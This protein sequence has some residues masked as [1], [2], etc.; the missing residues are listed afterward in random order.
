MRAIR[1]IAIVSGMV[2]VVAVVAYLWVARAGGAVSFSDAGIERAVRSAL[3]REDASIYLTD[4]EQI[5]HLDAARYGIR[6][7]SEIDMLSNLRTLDLSGNEIESL[8][9]LRELERLEELRLADFGLESADEVIPEHDGRFPTL[10]RLNLENNR[11]L[12]DIEALS[13]LT[14]LQNLSLRNTAVDDIQVIGELT[15]LRVLD[16]RETP[17]AGVDL[18]AL[19]RLTALERLN[20]RET[21]IRDVAFLHGLSGLRYLNLHS[22]AG[23]ESL[24]P[25][26]DL[27]RLQT[28]ILRN[29]PIGESP[30]I[31][32]GMRSLE[33]VNLRNTGIAD[34][35][36]IADLMSRGALQDDPERGIA[37][38]VD[39]RDNQVRGDEYELLKPYWNRISRR[40][41]EELPR[42]PSR[43][44]IISEVMTSNGEVA[45]GDQD[46]FPDWIELHNPGNQPVEIGGYHLSRDEED[47]RQWRIPAGTTI[48]GEGYLVVVAST[49]QEDLPPDSAFLRAPFNL[50]SDGEVVSLTDERGRRVI[51]QLRVPAIP[52]N[53]SY[54]R[55][56]G[57]EAASGRGT[58]HT[59]VE[60]TPGRTNAGAPRYV[61]VEFSHATGFYGTPFRLALLAGTDGDRE[62]APDAA[63]T[64]TDDVHI[65]YT[66]DGSVPDPRSAR[67]AE[68]GDSREESAT[69]RYTGPI[70][71]D[72]QISRE[73]RLAEIPTTIA[74][75][76]LWE[77]RPPEEYGP[78]GTVVRAVAYEGVLR[79][80][81][82]TATYVVGDDPPELPALFIAAEPERLF[83]Y[84]EGIY[85]PGRVYDE[86]RD[87]YDGHWMGAPANYQASTEVPAHLQF[88]EAVGEG[89]FAVDGGI[90]IHGGW[91]RSHPLKSLRLYARKRY[92][93]TDSFNYQLFPRSPVAS[94]RRLVLRSGQS[95][96]RSHVQDSLIHRHLRDHVQVELLE[97]RPVVHFINGEYWGIKHLQ[98]RFDQHYLEAVYGVHPEDS[99]ILEGPVGYDSQLKHGEISDAQEFR[100]VREYVMRHDMTDPERYAYVAHRLD[101]DSFIDYNI[102]RMYAA[103]SDGVTKHIAVWRLRGDYTP[104]AEAPGDGR[105]RWHTWDFDNS[106]LFVESDTI[107][108]Y[109][110]DRSQEEHYG[111]VSGASEPVDP[112]DAPTVRDPEYTALFANLIENETFRNR[113]VSRF[114]DLLNTVFEPEV[115]TAGI[116]NAAEELEPEIARHIARWNYP[117]STSYWRQQV[118]KHRVFAE[119]RPTI[120]R[121]HIIQYLTQRGWDVPGTAELEVG[122]PSPDY[123]TVRVNTVVLDG[124]M[125]G[126]EPEAEM[127]GTEPEAAWTGRYFQGVPVELEALPAEGYRFSGWDWDGPGA[128][129]TGRQITINPG[130]T[131]WIQPEFRQEAVDDAEEQ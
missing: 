122:L 72:G 98:E 118:D 91:S 105:W 106:L 109:G 12:R 78:T 61:E 114:A 97:S 117:D 84:E 76:D 9:P 35:S 54:G 30:D 111:T 123:G 31:L 68:S 19:R 82:A 24:D 21:G 81:V 86:D 58:A 113:F 7:I 60:P 75:A 119:E 32:A 103:D 74:E 16:L 70:R 41:P 49:D 63:E 83:G 108:F 38:E 36:V 125:P 129:P 100:E 4:L 124:E 39:L 6:D 116:T 50:S 89:G 57:S 20:L 121:E 67:G 17:L 127:P 46:R 92:D 25:L 47:L 73:A 80:D 69:Y 48:P 107:T 52:R 66:L 22:N 18:D 33:R 115:L 131:R 95:L 2:L 128:A 64:D 110:N 53:T 65:Y 43:E 29:V 37:A 59:Y 40:F 26:R 62:T 126:T 102:V 28:L 93:R 112:E 8:R 101:L 3:Q 56:E 10:V 130:E 94:H 13:R 14:A 90:R 85:V 45:V 42:T 34:L 11:S 96:F 79:S 71:I 77:W 44:I 120:Q 88:R 27:R 104:E 55:A 1:R 23:I 99:V 87:E 5:T 51:D 15:A